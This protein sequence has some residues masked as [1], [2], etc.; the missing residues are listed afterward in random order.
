MIVKVIQMA[1][2]LAS[3]RLRE[4]RAPKPSVPSFTMPNPPCRR[5]VKKKKAKQLKGRG[6]ASLWGSPYLLYQCPWALGTLFSLWVSGYIPK[7]IPW[8]IYGIIIMSK[9]TV[10]GC[11]QMHVETSIIPT[12]TN[13][14]SFP[15][16]YTIG[17]IGLL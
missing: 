10:P 14:S 13:S 1:N 3:S 17:Y 7:N 15:M 9:T 5:Q 8:L 6:R 4:V 16:K 11:L 2:P 12:Y